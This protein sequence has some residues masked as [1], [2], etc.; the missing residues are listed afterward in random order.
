MQGQATYRYQN[1]PVLAA[2]WQE[3]EPTRAPPAAGTL[4]R[5][6]DYIRITNLQKSFNDLE[7]VA[8]KFCG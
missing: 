4:A 6:A 7:Q 3:R 1:A 5:D 2:H 8:E